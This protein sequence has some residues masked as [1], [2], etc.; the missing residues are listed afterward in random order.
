VFDEKP[1][2]AMY[3]TNAVMAAADIGAPLGV[4]S[5]LT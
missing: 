4:I 5:D 1:S 2:F 3:V